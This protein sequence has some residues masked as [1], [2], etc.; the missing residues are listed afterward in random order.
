MDS[1]PGD[2]AATCGG[3]MEPVRVEMDASEEILVHRCVRC[4][5][6][7]RNKVASGDEYAR[8]AEVAKWS[9]LSN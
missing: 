2:R 6:E 5:Y 8:I 7:K 4:G 1:T 3:M 9:S